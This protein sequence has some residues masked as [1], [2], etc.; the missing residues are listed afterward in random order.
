[1]MDPYA[2]IARNIVL[3]LW[4]IRDKNPYLR[5]IPEHVRNEK[6]PLGQLK[7]L[8]WQRLL[9]LIQH[10]YE[11]T[12]YYKSLFD[13]LKLHPSDIKN[14]E[15][16]QALPV[17]TKDP[18]RERLDDF[19]AKNID[20]DDLIKARTGGSTGVPLAF[21]RDRRCQ[22]MRNAATACFEMWLGF[23]PGDRK[24]LIWGA[25]QDLCW[26]PGFKARVREILVDR[27]ISFDARNMTAEAAIAFARLLDRF[28][29]KLILTYPSAIE[30]FARFISANGGKAPRMPKVIVTAE[31]MTPQQRELAQKIL[32]CEIF[33]RY[34]SREVGE[35]AMECEEHNGYHLDPQSHYVEIVRDGRPAKPGELGQIV[36]T[37]LL[38]YG[39]PLIRYLHGDLAIATDRVCL[40]GRI[41]P[42]IESIQG[43]FSDLIITPSGRVVVGSIS[44]AWLSALEN[45]IQQAQLIQEDINTIKVRLAGATDIN[46]V[47]EYITKILKKYLGSDMVIE[48]ELVDNI[49]CEQSG[50]Y[51]YVVSKLSQSELNRAFRQQKQ[52]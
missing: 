22:S 43:R 48:Y 20:P 40:C 8:Q 6:L 39:M 16:I 32:S 4:G 30:S 50:K 19:L 21:C 17:L 23:K 35:I 34:G 13:S 42:M 12:V 25:S 36:I 49:P 3:P 47:K 46:S 9:A 51:R 24:A 31:A 37:D 44:S 14:P 1:M 45:Q 38:N 41:S 26:S 10:A 29:P 15:D 18:M 2:F 11:N 27:C 33:D 28:N 7:E 5:Y 52:G